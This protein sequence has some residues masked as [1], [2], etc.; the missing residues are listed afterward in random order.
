MSNSVDPSQVHRML[1]WLILMQDAKPWP[2]SLDEGLRDRFISSAG[3]LSTIIATAL[4][5]FEEGDEVALLRRTE[6]LSPNQVAALLGVS[7]KIVRRM[8]D[9]QTLRAAQLPGSVHWRVPASEVIRILDEDREFW[10]EPALPD[11]E[12]AQAAAKISRAKAKA[13]KAT[14]GTRTRVEA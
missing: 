14:E 4:D 1:R 6:T 10:A 11:V 9:E 5:A 2:D 7:R 12:W 8:I 13:R 3:D